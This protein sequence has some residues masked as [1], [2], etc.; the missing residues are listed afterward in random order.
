[1]FFDH[2][3]GLGFNIISSSK[4]HLREKKIYLQKKRNPSNFVN[5]TS[6]GWPSVDTNFENGEILRVVR[7]EA[8]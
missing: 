4:V 8:I 7:T 1:M 2:R 5:F 6:Q 3:V